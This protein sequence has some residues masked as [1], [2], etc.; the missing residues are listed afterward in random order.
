MFATWGP[1]S[2]KTSIE[3]VEVGSTKKDAWRT[4]GAWRE[5]LFHLIK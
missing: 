5:D 4:N 2:Y 3:E 1:E